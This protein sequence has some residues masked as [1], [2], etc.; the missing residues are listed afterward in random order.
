MLVWFFLGANYKQKNHDPLDF[1]PLLAK[2]LH[3][4]PTCISCNWFG[5]KLL[6]IL[7]GLIYDTECFLARHSASSWGCVERGQPPDREGAGPE[8]EP[9]P[10]PC[11]S[12]QMCFLGLFKRQPPRRCEYLLFLWTS[13]GFLCSSSFLK[14]SWQQ[15]SFPLPRRN[16]KFWDTVH[17]RRKNP[18]P[19]FG[20]SPLLSLPVPVPF[21]NLF[22]EPALS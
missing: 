7:I 9:E 11:P 5:V 2:T 22:L 16:A 10:D 19:D 8:G 20:K 4:A 14:G 1:K 17:W 6:Q 13:S 3:Q 15:L 12:T 18:V 21:R